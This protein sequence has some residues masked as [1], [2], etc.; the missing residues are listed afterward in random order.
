LNGRLVKI[1]LAT[2]AVGILGFAGCAAPTAE[3]SAIVRHVNA[4]ESA[5]RAAVTKAAAVHGYHELTP[6]L[7]QKTILRQR[8][9]ILGLIPV[10]G[11][12]QAALAFRVTYQTNETGTL[13]T[14]APVMQFKHLTNDGYR[15]RNLPV[16]SPDR[17]ELVDMID[18]IASEADYAKN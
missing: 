5:T 18:R 12:P 16:N 2:L 15:E 17:A 4:T 1:I 6:G 13:V 8:D 11:E 9:P 3:T 14:V 7:F 10:D